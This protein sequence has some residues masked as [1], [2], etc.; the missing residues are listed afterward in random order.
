MEVN[1]N[2]KWISV[3]IKK[4][5]TQLRL[6]EEVIV[7]E[8]KSERSKITGELMVKM[9]KLNPHEFLRNNKKKE[10]DKLKKEEEEKKV[11]EKE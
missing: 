6:T 2:P 10:A 5:L 1:I 8:S 3:R 7:H 11:K 4:Q 9:K